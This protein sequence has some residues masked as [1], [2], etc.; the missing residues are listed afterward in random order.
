MLAYYQK[1]WASTNLYLHWKVL[2]TENLIQPHLCKTFRCWKMD[3]KGTLRDSVHHSAW[4]KIRLL[5][6]CLFWEGNTANILKSDYLSYQC[7]HK[8]WTNV[9]YYDTEKITSQSLVLAELVPEISCYLQVQL[10]LAYHPKNESVRKK[11]KEEWL[12]WGASM[13]HRKNNSTR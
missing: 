3:L 13:S 12:R 7:C 8:S 11:Q 1:H 6:P 9:S 10:S 2:S 5:F 4:R